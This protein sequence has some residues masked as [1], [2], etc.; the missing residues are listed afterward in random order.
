M[1][2]KFRSIKRATLR[3]EI[4][5]EMKKKI[6]ARSNPWIIQ[7]R[8]GEINQEKICV[9]FLSQF[10]CLFLW[11]NEM[12]WGLLLPPPVSRSCNYTKVLLCSMIF[13]LFFFRKGAIVLFHM[14]QLPC[15]TQMFM[16]ASYCCSLFCEG[17]LATENSSLEWPSYFEPSS[18]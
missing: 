8:N 18:Y 12:N 9:Y 13:A 4:I 1:L 6:L 3:R 11:F 2:E 15:G 17:I 10:F 14:L 7:T 16:F 5:K